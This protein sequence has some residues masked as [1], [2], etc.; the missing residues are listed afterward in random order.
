M[1]TSELLALRDRFMARL[2]QRLAD[3]HVLLPL[4]QQA[5]PLALAQ[6]QRRSHNLVGAAGLH[7]LEDI[8]RSATALESA[9]RDTPAQAAAQALQTSLWSAVAQD[10]TTAFQ[11]H[12][13]PTSPRLNWSEQVWQC[14]TFPNQLSSLIALRREFE[15]FIQH[16]PLP[17]DLID[18]VTLVL[19]EV[20]SNVVRHGVPDA[21]AV[22]GQ[23]PVGLLLG[24]SHTDEL[25]AIMTSEG[26]AFKPPSDI[27]SPEALLSE[28]GGYGLAIIHSCCADVRFDSHEGLNICHM[29]WRKQA[30]GWL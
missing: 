18:R 14:W 19:V 29:H 20:F 21:A 23:H 28:D 15:S 8:V 25:Q 3:M 6:L 17:E 16:H 1:S 27:N 7:G 9:L 5:H 4:A 12:A 11:A 26:P 30:E 24:W 10:I 22:P 13:H 2:P